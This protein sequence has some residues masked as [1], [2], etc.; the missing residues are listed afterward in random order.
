MSDQINSKNLCPIPDGIQG[1]SQ[2]NGMIIMSD[3][4]GQYLNSSVFNR[5]DC[6]VNW[7]VFKVGETELNIN[8]CQHYVTHLK[9]GVT[10]T[11]SDW[12]PRYEC[13]SINRQPVNKCECSLKHQ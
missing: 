1:Y 9:G 4:G 8:N 11:F 6:Q 2:Y 10:Y 5:H 12:S 13:P 3:Y 7:W